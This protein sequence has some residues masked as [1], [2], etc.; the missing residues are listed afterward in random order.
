MYEIGDRG[1]LVVMA[2]DDEPTN[3]IIYTWDE[4]L[5]WVSLNITKEPIYISNIATEP[6][7][8]EQKF[9]IYGHS[10]QSDNEIDKYKGYIISLDFQLHKRACWGSWDPTMP[11]SDYELWTPETN[12]EN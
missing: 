3:K 10:E 6:S 8:L 2:R 12:D 1:G 11:E 9:I 7:N 5:T 4:G